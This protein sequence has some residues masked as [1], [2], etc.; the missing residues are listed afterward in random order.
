[1]DKKTR[2]RAIIRGRVQGV[3]FRAETKRAADELG[4]S[5]WVRNRPDRTSVEAEFEGDKEKVDSLIQW[6]HRGSR[7][8]NVTGV[9]I[10][11]DDFRG[12]AETFDIRY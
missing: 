12:D 7:L 11:R 8:S 10:V 5:G 2:V 1:M 9:D 6:L 4:V 3:F